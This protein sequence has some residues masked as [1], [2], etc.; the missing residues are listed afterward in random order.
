VDRS[1]RAPLAVSVNDQFLIPARKYLFEFDRTS[2][3]ARRKPA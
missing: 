2:A 1:R 3:Q